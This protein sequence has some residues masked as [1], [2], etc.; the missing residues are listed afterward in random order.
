MT[1]P[2]GRCNTGEEV[3]KLAKKLEAIRAKRKDRVRS[4]IEGTPERPRLSVFRSSRHIFVQA[5]V[6]DTGVT[7]AEASTL[8]KD[9]R[10][11]LQGKKKTEAAKEVGKLVSRRLQHLGIEQ[12]VFDRSRYLYHGRIKALA[13]AARE[14]GLKF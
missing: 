2:Y 1:V 5:I 6:D 12:V 14:A 8:S 13:D 4:K 10:D 9:L 11:S 3:I 7:I